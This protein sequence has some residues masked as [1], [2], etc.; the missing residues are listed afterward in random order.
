[1]PRKIEG[2]YDVLTI[3]KPEY[4]AGLSMRDLVIVGCS[5]LDI[6]IAHMIE[7]RLL[8]IQKEAEKFLG[9]DGDGRAPAGS[10]GARIQLALLLGVIRQ[11]D[12]DILRAYK[13]MRN[14]FAH[15]VNVAILDAQV[16]TFVKVIAK[17]LL[18]ILR[19]DG[20]DPLF[21]RQIDAYLKALKQDE[22]FTRQMIQ[23]GIPLLQV[24]YM[25]KAERIT[26]I[27]PV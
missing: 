26:R 1:M 9:Y 11:V 14:V 23:T 12:A 20:R 18:E 5:I 22:A 13:G 4:L 24:F 8:D 17:G 2:W 21:E 7:W 19:P 27:M 25:E 16:T 10:F 3:V 15:K 6:S